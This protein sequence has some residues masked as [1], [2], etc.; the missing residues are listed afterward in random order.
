MRVGIT[1]H[2]DLGTPDDVA[3]VTE[4]LR[5][6]VDSQTLHAGT[7][8]LAIGADQLYA[9][10]LA[11]YR[12]PFT[13]LIPCRHYE[14]TFTTPEHLER[15]HA[16]LGQATEVIYLPFDEP[17]SE[18][19]WEAGQRVVESSDSIIAVWNG[20]PAKGLG[21]TGDV[22]R[23]CLETGRAVLHINPRTRQVEEL[24]QPA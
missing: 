1:G 19:F 5:A 13:A 21:G 2:Q 23:H 17:S 24:R 15:Y 8:S 20:L 16:L 3:W 9:S 12:K 10:L 7:T 22:V 11:R 18:A 4:Q 6:R 14:R